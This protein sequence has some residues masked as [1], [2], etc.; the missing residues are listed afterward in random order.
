M[1]Y[2][3]GQDKSEGGTGF[4]INKEVKNHIKEYKKYTHRVCSIEE[5]KGNQAIKYIQVYAPTTAYS[6]M[7]VEEFYSNLQNAVNDAKKCKQVIVMGDFNGKVGKQLSKVKEVGKHG[8]GE[9]NKRGQRLIEFAMGNKLYISNTFFE[10]QDQNKWTWLH[11]NKK[12]KNQ[13]D[14][15]LHSKNTTIK[16]IEVVTDINIGSDH[17]AVGAKMGNMRK[18]KKWYPESLPK[19]KTE[20]LISKNY[21]NILEELFKGDNTS[22][23]EDIDKMNQTINEFMTNAYKQS[24]QNDKRN[25]N[26]SCRKFP[27]KIKNLMNKRRKMMKNNANDNIEY[28][29]ICK[30]IR[31]EIKDWQRD[32]EIERITKA[33]EDNS[34]LKNKDQRKTIIT[35]MK[36][37]TGKE[38]TQS[39]EILEI[40]KE[41]YETLYS[42]DE[43][44]IQEEQFNTEHNTNT[45][46]KLTILNEEIEWAVKNTK[47]GKAGG[48]DGITIEHIKAG[49]STIVNAL[50]KLFNKCLEEAK[51]PEEWLISK[52]VL[53]KKKGS[54]KEIK[55][56]RPLSLLQISYKLFTKIIINRMDSIFNIQLNQNQAGFRAGFSTLDHI[57]VVNEV[58]DK[59]VS[60]NFKVCL[61]FIDYEK[62]FDRIK[63]K[64]ILEVL[65]HYGIP[66][67]YINIFKYIY[68][69]S[70][71]KVNVNGQQETEIK[72]NRG[73]K[74]GDTSSPKLFI[75]VLAYVFSKLNWEEKGLKVN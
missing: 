28:V 31:T 58:I 27:A 2:N 12:I 46:I 11:P 70:K 24:V 29:Q 66:Q 18:E 73:V 16:D 23:N 3:N 20:H 32:K 60:Y 72:I 57:H 50:N 13:I 22:N 43:E 33:L 41:Y 10:K 7:E 67:V 15:I 19:V 63:T 49:G 65:L 45:D 59:A 35:S 47:E 68:E 39:E 54:G 42:N 55:N 9:A 4:L 52:L 36:D 5:R 75:M 8:L 48:S 38:K 40:I 62:A 56:Y 34:A 1:F 37:K 61:V 6:D 30:K 74:Q 71:A 21:E 69:N 64:A 51:V 53:L 44:E 26:D 25:H 14:Y 17:R